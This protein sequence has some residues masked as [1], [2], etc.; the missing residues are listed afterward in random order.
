MNIQAT[1]A[2][3]P[4]TASAAGVL[5]GV[6]ISFHCERSGVGSVGDQLSWGN[7][8][9]ANIGMVM[10]FSGKL[11]L[12]TLGVTAL[13][14]THT[15]QVKLNGVV[16]PSYQLSATGTAVNASDIKNWQS[17]PLAFTVGSTICWYTSVACTSATSIGV[18]FFVVFD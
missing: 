17:T 9:S 1:T 13:T 14:G 15:S 11:I 10:P 7:G 8:T 2:A 18:T 5:G 16:N 12:A 3:W 4:G 6:P